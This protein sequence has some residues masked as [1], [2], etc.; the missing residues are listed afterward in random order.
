VN[1]RAARIAE[2]LAAAR[3]RNQLPDFIGE[4]ELY[5]ENPDCAV[6]EV[7]LTI[8]EQDGQMPSGLI[9]PACRRQLKVHYVLTLEEKRADDEREARCSVNAQRY[10]RDHPDEFAMPIGVLLDEALP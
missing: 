10:R 4:A 3:D 7:V 1:R 8:K 9:C 6:R 2:A 5:C